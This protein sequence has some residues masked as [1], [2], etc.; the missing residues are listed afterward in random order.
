MCGLRLTYNSNLQIIMLVLVW[1]HRM[2]LV[3]YIVE[4]HII[5]PIA[6]QLLLFYL[7]WKTIINRIK[8]YINNRSTLKFKQKTNKKN[9]D[10]YNFLI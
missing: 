1:V 9:F 8:I 4:E 6:L 7:Q 10:Y 2:H 5:F 3:G